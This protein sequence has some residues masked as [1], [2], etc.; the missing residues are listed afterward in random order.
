MSETNSDAVAA[1]ANPV[2]TTSQEVSAG[3][4]SAAISRATSTGL[5]AAP[6]TTISTI[7]VQSG[8]TRIVLALLQVI[9]FSLIPFYLSYDP[10]RSLGSRHPLVSHANARNKLQAFFLMLDQ[11]ANIY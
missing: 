11:Y 6:T 4:T 2:P 9:I 1:A 5:P 8:D 7:A 10:S 3:E